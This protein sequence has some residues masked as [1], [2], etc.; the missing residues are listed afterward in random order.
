[1][2]A[3]ELS[4]ARGGA[5]DADLLAQQPFYGTD[6]TK[7]LLFLEDGKLLLVPRPAQHLTGSQWGV[8]NETG[9]YPG[10]PWLWL[11]TLW[12]QIPGWRTSAN[13]D[14]IAI[15][16][17]GIATILLLW[18]RSSPG[19]ATSRADPGAPP[20]LA[21]SGGPAVQAGAAGRD[22]ARAAAARPA[23]T[24]RAGLTV[25]ERTYQGPWS[26]GGR[27]LFAVSPWPAGWQ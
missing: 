21:D 13:V 15:Y 6:Y 26:A 18:Y 17:T 24:I 8:M 2:V 5:L 3:S 19:F 7:P 12:Y 11:Y 1:M 10:Q 22:A 27:A 20:G 9:S 14:L 4:M 16:M 25:P 23:G